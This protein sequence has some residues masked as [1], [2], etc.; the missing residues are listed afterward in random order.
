M[1]TDF[2]IYAW[3][4]TSFSPRRQRLGPLGRCLYATGGALLLLDPLLWSPGG[5]VSVL[6][7]SCYTLAV[8]EVRM[9]WCPKLLYSYITPCQLAISGDYNS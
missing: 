1:G 7:H 5:V 2:G 6:S 8:S 9:A 3:V 4:Q